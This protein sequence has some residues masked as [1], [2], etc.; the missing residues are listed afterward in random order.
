MR[1]TA[2]EKMELIDLVERTDLPV[3]VTLR[4]L[5]IPPSTFYG[6]YK[7]Y[8]EGGFDGLED[9]KPSLKTR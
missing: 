5:G 1:R 6:W 3:R 8:L 7:R 2:S 9:K 4:Q